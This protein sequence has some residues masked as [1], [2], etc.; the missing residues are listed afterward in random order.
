[1]GP[2]QAVPSFAAKY[3][4]NCSYC[5]NAWPELNKRGRRFKEMGYRLPEDF[6]KDI[7]V[8]S[9]TELGS[10]PISTRLIARP[11]DRADVGGG[12]EPRLRAL[13]EVEVFVAGAVGKHWSAYFE[14]EAEDENDFTPEVTPAVL[15]YN[16]NRPLNVH[17][18]WAPV[19]W[20][21][22]YSILSENTK[23]TRGN[24]RVIDRSFGG[25]D[26]DGGALSTDRQAL[27]VWG[28]LA[29]TGVPYL[30][31]FFYIVGI[32]GEAG[33]TEGVGAKNI[34][35]R[36]AFDITDDIMI[37][38]FLIDG[39]TD[40]RTVTED[41]TVTLDGVTDVL[42]RI[43]TT[44][45]DRDFSRYGADFQADLYWLLGNT[46]FAGA[47]VHGEDDDETA[48]SEL[49]SD[50]YSI[51]AFHVFREKGGKPTVVPLIR[52]DYTEAATVDKELVFNMG[53]YI[54]Q[55]ARAYLEYLLPVDAPDATEDDERLTLQ[56][57]LAF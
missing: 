12:G 32:N 53:Y 10:F 14:F 4:K 19:F 28:R 55:N 42:R 48:T 16:Y 33:D 40:R 57:E 24:P 44:F 49:D 37:G 35:A 39:E 26:G 17:A 18:A 41:T 36:L 38:G 11:Y 20:A 56:I 9:Y 52:Y 34:D 43:D 46:R 2:A 47:Y 50:V 3:E 22:P 5:H 13:H 27:N 29:G 1:M 31:R 8:S 21:D 6:K 15:G 25:A 23:L 7:P 45:P 51:Q 30:E 54:D